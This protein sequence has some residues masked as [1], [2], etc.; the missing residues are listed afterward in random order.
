LTGQCFEIG[1]KNIPPN[2]Y[3]Q[4][5]KII[6]VELT[7]HDRK[8]V[9]NLIKTIMLDLQN[10]LFFFADAQEKLKYKKECHCTLAHLLVAAFG[11]WASPTTSKRANIIKTNNSFYAN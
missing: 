11:G 9:K 1:N 2:R 3:T 10:I 5:A 6:K 8:M 4:G 7:K